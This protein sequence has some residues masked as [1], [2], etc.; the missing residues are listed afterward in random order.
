MSHLYQARIEM[1]QIS[2]REV[3][4]II[5]GLG[6]CGIDERCCSNFLTEFSPIS[7]KHAKEQNLSLNPHDITGMCGRLRC[8]L[9]FEY[10]Q[11]VAAKRTLPKVKSMIG[12]PKGR[13][14]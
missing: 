3:A 6:A 12:T 8:C 1:R 9:V 5:G 4:K 2:P 13:A 7:I 10:E 11:Y 14:R